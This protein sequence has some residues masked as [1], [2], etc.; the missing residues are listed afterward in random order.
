MGK[1]SPFLSR[2]S[3]AARVFLAGHVCGTTSDHVTKTAGH[4][5]VLHSDVLNI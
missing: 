2:F 3:L 4:L 5:H 1:L